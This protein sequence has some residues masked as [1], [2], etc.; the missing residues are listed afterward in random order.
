MLIV[1]IFMN[2][3][4]RA[5]SYRNL[6]TEKLV[7]IKQCSSKTMFIELNTDIK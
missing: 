7:K 4:Q 5:V 3:V 1:Y 6:E 2:Y